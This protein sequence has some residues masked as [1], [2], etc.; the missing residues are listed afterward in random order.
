MFAL[1][2]S[3]SMVARTHFGMRTDTWTFISSSL[4]T[5]YPTYMPWTHTNGT[6]SPVTDTN[7]PDSAMS[8]SQTEYSSCTG[9]SRDPSDDGPTWDTAWATLYGPLA[10]TQSWNYTSITIPA[11]YTDQIVVSWQEVA[12][13]EK[14]E[15]TGQDP[16]DVTRTLTAWSAEGVTPNSFYSGIPGGGS[17]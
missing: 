1:L 17:G 7:P 9:D 4:T 14:W 5:T 16:N 3:A 8:G 10:V 2:A 15:D 6:A 13:S 12:G 11:Y